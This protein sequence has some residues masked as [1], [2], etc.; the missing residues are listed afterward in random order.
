MSQ[1]QKKDMSLNSENTTATGGVIPLNRG[2][3]SRREAGDLASHTVVISEQMVK[4]YAALTGDENPIH[5]D[6]E[7][8]RKSIFGVNI[9][10]GMLVGSLFG[11]IIVNQLIGP[12]VLYRKQTLEFEAPVPIGE[13][14]TA[15]V[16]VREVK[17]KPDKDIYI[18]QTDCFLPSGQRAITGE[19]VI[20]ALTGGLQR[21]PQQ[22]NGNA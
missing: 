18:L 8:G 3:P 9:A 14:V 21:D 15:T 12:G 11:P 16:T 13:E 17:S 5:I 10:H 20:I 2:K 1:A 7:S 22:E 6:K 19:A 4:L